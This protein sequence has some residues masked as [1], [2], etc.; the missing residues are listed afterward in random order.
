MYNY[1]EIFFC[2]IFKFK[3]IYQS[4]NSFVYCYTFLV[5]LV[6]YQLPLTQNFIAYKIKSAILLNRTCGNDLNNNNKKFEVVS[7]KKH[8]V[9]VKNEITVL[10]TVI[11]V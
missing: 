11:T 2:I 3:N 8:S 5:V 1:Y 7:Y 10:R 4:F 6:G 9:Y